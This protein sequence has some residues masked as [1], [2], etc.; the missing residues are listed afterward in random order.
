MPPVCE[1]A[2]VSIKGSSYE[3]FRRALDAGSPLLV[4][5][6]AAELPRLSLADALAVTLVLSA[7]DRRRYERAAARWTARLCLETPGVTLS[8][9]QLAG[10][11]L[12]QLADGH[13]HSGGLALGAL[14]SRLGHRECERELARWLGRRG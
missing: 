8:D 4:T 14:L 7:D 13:S 12:Q 5:G 2:F 11:A 1:H 10:A 6:A 9:G 3:R